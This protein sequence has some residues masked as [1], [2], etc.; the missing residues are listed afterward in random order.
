M[1]K[2]TY[3][4]GSIAL[5]AMIAMSACSKKTESTTSTDALGS[6]LTGLDQLPSVSAMVTTNAASSSALAGRIGTVAAVSGTAPLLVDLGSGTAVDTYFFNG[7]VSTINTAQA[8]TQAQANQFFGQDTNGGPSGQGGCMMAQSVGENLGRMLQSGTT[9]CYMKNIPNAATGVT[10]TGSTKDQVFVQTDADKHV[11]ISVSGNDGGGGGG[12]G[13]EGGGGGGSMDVHIIVAGKTKVGSDVYQANLYFCQ[14]GNVRSKESL[15]VNR[16]TGEYTST[17]EGSESGM[18][19]R[20]SVKAYLKVGSDSKITFDASK[21]RTA[22]AM[23]TGTWGTFKGEMEITADDIIKAKRYNSSTWNDQSG[24]DKNY[25]ITS[26][27][28]T[29]L[30][31]LRFLEGAFKGANKWGS[32]SENTYSGATEFQDSFYKAVATSSMKTEVEAF[33]FASDSFFTDTTVSAPDFTGLDCTATGDIQLTM[34]FADSAVSAIREK[35]EADRFE[36]Y[37]MCYNETTQAAQ[38]YVFQSMHNNH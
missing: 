8:A 23:G 17:S 4:M 36:N 35:C 12:G 29:N 11:K 9:A 28:G 21:S 6:S 37:N 3:V 22:I 30:K 1:K 10:I 13:G 2:Q 18:T 5:S 33:N 7:L 20:E 25:S 38:N 16:T 27:S 15:T 24:V 34:D 32:Y 26:F 19:H 14:G 31:S